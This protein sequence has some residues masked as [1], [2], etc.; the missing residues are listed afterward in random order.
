MVKVIVFKLSVSISDVKDIQKGSNGDGQLH[1]FG[2][3]YVLLALFAQKYS[4]QIQYF[5]R[6]II[7][8]ARIWTH[9]LCGIKADALAIE[10]S[11]LR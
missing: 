4:I 9:D 11:R 5:F 6:K 1:F 3:D 8:L 2:W 7:S 10:L